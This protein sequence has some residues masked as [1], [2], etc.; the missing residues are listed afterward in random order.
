MDANSPPWNSPL[1]ESHY[2]VLQTVLQGCSIIDELTGRCQQAG[3]DVNKYVKDNTARK[4]LAA[5]L[6]QAFFPDR[7]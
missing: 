6:K 4:T 2:T 7:P 3:L 1:N 5:G